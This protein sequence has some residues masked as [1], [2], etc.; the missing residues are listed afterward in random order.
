MD[1]LAASRNI[2]AHDP[3]GTSAVDAYSLSAIITNADLRHMHADAFAEAL[4]SK[5][6]LEAIQQRPLWASLDP[7]VRHMLRVKQAKG[8]LPSEQ[9]ECSR[10]LAMYHVCRKMLYLR[11]GTVLEEAVAPLEGEAEEGAEHAALHSN[12]TFSA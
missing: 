11:P 1:K 5:A 2:P 10:W 7:F 8:L 3:Q 12:I 9:T 6:K 4:K